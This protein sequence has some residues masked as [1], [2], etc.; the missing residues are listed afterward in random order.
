M[1]PK[2]THP[3]SRSAAAAQGDLAAAQ[4]SV[5][6]KDEEMVSQGSFEMI[7]RLEEITP[8]DY[9]M[10]EQVAETR[11]NEEDAT[12]LALA[13]EDASNFELLRWAGVLLMG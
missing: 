9:Q 12:S 7:D 3:L 8:A 2:M 1:A 4:A 5:I 6:D 10:A 13:G 11:K